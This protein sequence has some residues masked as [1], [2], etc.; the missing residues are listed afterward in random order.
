MAIEFVMGWLVGAP[1]GMFIMV[2]LERRLWSYWC[3]NKCKKLI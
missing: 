1:V 3:K 2:V